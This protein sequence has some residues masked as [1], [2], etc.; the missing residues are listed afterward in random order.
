MCVRVLFPLE[1]IEGGW[2]Q[3]RGEGDGVEGVSTQICRSAHNILGQTKPF[4]P[5][6]PHLTK[7]RE[8]WL[9]KFI[10]HHHLLY[11]VEQVSMCPALPGGRDGRVFWMCL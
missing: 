4:F 8:R 10:V 9:I 2:G 11:F 3:H 6:T 5:F 1:S 7:R